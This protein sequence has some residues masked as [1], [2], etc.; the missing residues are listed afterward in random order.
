MIKDQTLTRSHA[1]EIRKA[2]GPFPASAASSACSIVKRI[3]NFLPEDWSPKINA[4]SSC[5]EVDAP[6]K[7]FGHNIVFKYMELAKNSEAASPKECSGYDSL[8]DEEQTSS[9]SLK[10]ELISGLFH[11]VENSYQSHTNG[12]EMVAEALPSSVGNKYTAEWLKKECQSC[13]KT[14]GLEWQELYSAIFQIMSSTKDNSEIQNDV[15]TCILGSCSGE[16]LRW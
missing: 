15:S 9:N 3:S 2:L 6:V 4:P 8:S 5:M 11:K 13:S 10:F 1:E 12:E 16:E 7:E 14:V